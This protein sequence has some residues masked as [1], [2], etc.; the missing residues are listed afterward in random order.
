M[1]CRELMGAGAWAL[2]LGVA[3]A[4]LAHTGGKAPRAVFADVRVRVVGDVAATLMDQQ[5][6]Q[7]G[8][9]GHK[10]EGIPLCSLDVME[11]EVA[12]PMDYTFLFRDSGDA[13]YRLVLA[14]RT[15]GEVEIT[16]DAR[17]N[18]GKRCRVSHGR[19][20]V[21]GKEYQW[22]IRWSAMRDSCKAEVAEIQGQGSRNT[23][24]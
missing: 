11:D 4:S 5:G 1:R 21:D 10:F 17:S 23:A 13:T 24:K 19:R 12:E 7:T 8:W 3:T 2:V 6:R 18:N 22:R 9:R 14:P 16:V 15:E 20:L